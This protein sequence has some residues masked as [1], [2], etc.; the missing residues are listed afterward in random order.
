MTEG[1]AD[2]RRAHCR[3]DPHL[4]EARAARHLPVRADYLPQ[5]AIDRGRRFAAA[6]FRP[7]TDGVRALLHRDANRTSA[8]PPHPQRS[9]LP[10]LSRRSARPS[11]SSPAR[12]CGAGPPSSSPPPATRFIPP[13]GRGGPAGS[14]AR[15]PSGRGWSPPT[16]ETG[17]VHELAAKFPS[18]AAD[19]RAIAD[20]VG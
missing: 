17:N 20:S 2:G 19:L 7:A 9:A 13:G 1:C 16:F 10:L 11:A 4:A 14:W 5:P 3:R 12:T 18:I 8:A 6:L 15:A